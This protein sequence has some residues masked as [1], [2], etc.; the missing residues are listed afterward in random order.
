MLHVA[1]IDKM[2]TDVWQFSAFHL[3]K[4]LSLLFCSLILAAVPT[5][6]A[7]NDL[8]DVESQN[9]LIAPTVMITLLVR[10]KEHTLPWFLGSIERLRYPKQ[11]ISL[12]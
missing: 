8:H 9:D 10:N 4:M 1:E 11:R 12:W 2:A 7:V 6:N 3:K 5:S